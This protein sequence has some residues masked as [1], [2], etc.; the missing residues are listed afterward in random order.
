M[1]RPPRMIMFGGGSWRIGSGALGDTWAYDRRELWT[2]L[3]FGGGLPLD[4]RRRWRT[5]RA[6]VA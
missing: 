6:P 4:E 2:D 5:I 3:I 1:T